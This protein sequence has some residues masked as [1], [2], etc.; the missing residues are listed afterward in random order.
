M[1]PDQRRAEGMLHLLKS[2]PTL[3]PPAPTVPAE[4]GPGIERRRQDEI[5]M[6]LRCGH[7]AG[8]AL[9][10]HTRL[11]P[12]WLDL[13]FGCRHWLQKSLPPDLPESP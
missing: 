8:V 12:R 10:A 11:G 6:C 7:R 13:C 2:E 9:I 3:L 4:M 1:T 5:H